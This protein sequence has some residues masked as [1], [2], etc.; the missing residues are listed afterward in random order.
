MKITQD[1]RE[2][3]KAIAAAQAQQGMADKSA[4]FM[5]KGGKIY[6]SR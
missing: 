6:V 4:E 5:G 2:E 1:L 3:S